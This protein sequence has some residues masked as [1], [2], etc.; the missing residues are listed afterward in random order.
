MGVAFVYLGLHFLACNKRLLF[1]AIVIASA[2]MFHNAVLAFLMLL[3]FTTKKSLLWVLGMLVVAVLLYP[4]NL[5]AFFLELSQNI[6]SYFNIEGTRLNRL[7]AFILRP[8]SD[9][10]L[11]VFRPIPL[12]VYFCAIVIFQY[13]VNF[14]AFERL[15]YNALILSI[16]F[17]ILL[18]DVVDLQVRFGDMFGF[19]LVFLVPYVHR[20][21]S[22]YFGARKAYIILY[23]FFIIHLVKYTLYDKMLIL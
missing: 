6:L 22:E 7:T 14:N 23:S 18:K 21:L 11:G 9:V 15:C 5:N 16:F 1:S 20:G 19:S 17:Y 12:L 3:F 4:V 2:I 13:R 8:S 10:F